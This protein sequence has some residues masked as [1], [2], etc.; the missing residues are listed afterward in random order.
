MN[1][2][3]QNLKSGDIVVW[4]AVLM[5][6]LSAVLCAGYWLLCC[7]AN[8]KPKPVNFLRVQILAVLGAL[9]F[10][11]TQML[12]EVYGA[13]RSFLSCL[14]EGG[15]NAV[16][17]AVA[18][19]N[20]FLIVW[21]LSPEMEAAFSAA[22]HVYFSFLSMLAPALVA[23]VAVTFFRTPMFWIKF[24]NPLYRQNVLVFSDLNERALMYA[25]SLQAESAAREGIIK[26]RLDDK[27]LPAKERRALKREKRLKMIIFC[28][29][30]EVPAQGVDAMTIPH[31]VILRKSMENLRFLRTRKTM[32]RI[33]FYLVTD[34]E[35]KKLHQAKILQERYG[36]TGAQIICVSARRGM[37]YKIDELN[38]A[39][40]EK[41]KAK[42]AKKAEKLAE[43]Q[44]EKDAAAPEKPKRKAVL[45]KP[46]QDMPAE[47]RFDRQMGDVLP[48]C[49]S[50]AATLRTRYIEVMQEASDLVYIN[51]DQQPLLDEDYLELL[52]KQPQDPAFT[53]EMHRAEVL[54]LGV[55]N[56]GDELARSCLWYFQLPDVC[57]TVTVVDQDKKETVAARILREC[58]DFDNQLAR[59]GLENR[60]RLNVI[61]E[62][63][64][65]TALLEG[66]L[67]SKY[68]KIFVC[69]GDDDLNYEIALRVRRH[70]LRNPP[71]WGCPDIRA[72]IWSDDMTELIG[73]SVSIRGL[74]DDAIK[75]Y[76]EGSIAPPC[77]EGRYKPKCPIGLLGSMKDSLDKESALRIKALRYHAF[78]CDSSRMIETAGNEGLYTVKASDY[79]DFFSGLEGDRRSNYALAAHGECKKLWWRARKAASR[80]Q[81][82]NALIALGRAE[83]VRWCIFKLLDGDY[84]VPD[85]YVHLFF[86][87]GISANRDKV[88]T[89]RRYH[90]VVRPYEAVRELSRGEG[91]I[92]IKD[93][94]REG[95]RG[96][97]V[98]NLKLA[99]FTL[100]LDASGGLG[101]ADADLIAAAAAREF[102]EE[103]PTAAEGAAS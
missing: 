73:D 81:K 89:V 53:E 92:E 42:A 96:N 41:L 37:D 45:R 33:T 17:A 84:P 5:I 21:D 55:G 36:E 94:Q 12:A 69:T 16:R 50:A 3:Y 46:G 31:A 34:D 90:A 25:Q 102:G 63:D 101:A 56:I 60:A 93:K 30:E 87:G 91:R 7:V 28:S 97:I 39:M 48:E 35:N 64:L 43:K 44:A 6:G 47:I 14:L 15:M 98:T 32:E 57:V 83:H 77:G 8:N 74:N 76:P 72:V 29:D 10:L 51:L 52:K 18:M 71:E 40:K 22:D 4:S 100:L 59:V 38:A 68:H 99:F 85:R 66:L 95:W 88:D 27:S 11:N 54:V 13:A 80:E 58:P 103:E 49:S 78:Y 20:I 65:R 24:Y 79:E 86:G 70:Y 19:E 9:M 2:L 82:I 1:V 62:T 75:Y 26:A 61:G 67:E 23:S